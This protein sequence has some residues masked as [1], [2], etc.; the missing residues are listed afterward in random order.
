MTDDHE[1]RILLIEDS[2]T[3]V[4]LVRM[5]LNEALNTPFVLEQDASLGDGLKRLSEGRF[6]VLLLDLHVLDSAG[7]DTFLT[8]KASADSVPIVITSGEEDTDCA[9]RAI[10]EGACGFLVKGEYT[11]EALARCIRLAVEPTT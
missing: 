4:E 5:H 7:F 2:R 10:Q 11:S 6:D 9:A 1:L 8:A 3:Q